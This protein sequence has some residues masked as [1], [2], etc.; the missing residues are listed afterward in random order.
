MAYGLTAL[1]DGNLILS[2]A[3][4]TTKAVKISKAG[5]VVSSVELCADIADV[6]FAEVDGT[7]WALA[8]N[9]AVYFSNDMGATWTATGIA[10][11]NYASVS[12]AALGKKGVYVT[13]ADESELKIYSKVWTIDKEDT[14][15]YGWNNTEGT[16]VAEYTVPVGYNGKTTGG[17][18]AVFVVTGSTAATN[19]KT[20]FVDGGK[21]ESATRN[22][23][24]TFGKSITLGDSLSITFKAVKSQVATAEGT[25]V[26]FLRTYSD[27]RE[28]V[29]TSVE[30]SDECTDPTNAKNYAVPYPGIAAKEMGDNV[31]FAIYDANGNQ[32]T[33]LEKYS[34][35]TYANN[36]LKSTT[37]AKFATLLVDMLNY[38]AAAQVYIGYDVEHLV[39]A[40]LTEEQ[41][42]Y[43][44]DDLVIDATLQEGYINSLS[45]SAKSLT[46]K[47]TIEIAVKYTYM[48]G[49]YKEQVKN[50]AYAVATYTTYA[51]TPM[52]KRMELTEGTAGGGSKDAK[53]D[54]MST[55][56]MRTLINVKLYDA[57]DNVIE[58]T[59]L[60]YSIS[61][62][63]YNQLKNGYNDA[64]NLHV[65]LMRIMQFGDSAYAYMK[66]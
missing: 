63:V 44:S 48:S 11:G 31:Y 49:N 5:A 37:D 8:S 58:G 22:F 17:Q 62:Y 39:N 65:L 19:T 13:W 54:F 15:T 35:L 60:V 14:T 43:A 33:T 6:A 2:V 10:G 61:A 55:A 38:G 29:V 51:G 46:L 26:K 32:V 18:P 59:E 53:I 27:G 12:M 25:T 47:N 4:T 36:Q 52:E 57:N 21:I 45:P 50:A 66:K 20:Y 3:D 16:V 56:N 64:N 34:I 7:V 23:V 1:S 9:G 24:L 40:G 41:K 42:A 28:A 30:L